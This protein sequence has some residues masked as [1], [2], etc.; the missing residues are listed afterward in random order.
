MVGKTDQHTGPSKSGVDTA[1]AF[2]QKDTL[3]AFSKKDSAPAKTKRV[4]A[5]AIS[6]KDTA[7]AISKKYTAPAKSQKETTSAKSTKVT[8]PQTR[9]V[10]NKRKEVL[11]RP[12]ML[13]LG[14]RRLRKKKLITDDPLIDLPG[15]N[16]SLSPGIDVHLSTQDYL[17]SCFPDLSQDTFV[18]GFDPSQPKIDDPLAFSSPGT[19]EK[20][21]V[22][23][24]ND[25]QVA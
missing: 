5:P 23:E 24:L 14:T 12:G 17:Q 18:E 2:S 19:S 21:D 4:I 8:G 10:T 25:Y 1:P 15:V 9:K 7:P 13:E 20:I 16:L 11:Y 22:R 3:P 6:E